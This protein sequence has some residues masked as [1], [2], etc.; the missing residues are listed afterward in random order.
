[1]AVYTFID[2]Q[3]LSDFLS[4]YDL[5]ALIAFEG[6]EAGVSNSNFHLAM[7]S[8][9]YVLT[10]F[11]PH[12]VNPD[13]VPYFIDYAAHL[14]EA[15]LPVPDVMKNKEER[16]RGVLADKPAA[17]FR[18]MEGQSVSA[19]NITADHC[20]KAGRILAKMHKAADNFKGFQDNDYGLDRWQIWFKTMR[21]DLDQ[22]RVGLSS[23][24]KADMAYFHRRWPSLLPG[25]GIHAD[26]F[27]DNVFFGGG[28]VSGVIDF[29]FACTDFYIYD[30][31][32]AV[33]AWCFDASSAFDLAHYDKM[34][35]GY[36]SVRQLSEEEWEAFP[37]MCHGAAVRFVL[38]RAEEWLKH[39]SSPSGAMVTPHNPIDFV[40][41]RDHFAHDGR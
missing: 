40:K 8:G 37:V 41:R 16:R 2:L 39:T 26:Y 30:L 4:A 15:G 34:I 14:S 9:H 28:D 21:A 3:M 1:M 24:L 23:E 38:S 32:I 5:G 31:A 10:I 7:E 22:I 20:Y 33:N 29:H 27:P 19:K 17:I 12:R 36:Q 6:I 35:A 11:E 13:D 18:F 25:G